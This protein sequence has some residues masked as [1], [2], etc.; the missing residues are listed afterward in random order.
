M[1]SWNARKDS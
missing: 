1:E